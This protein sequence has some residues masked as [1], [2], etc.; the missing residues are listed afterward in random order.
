MVE[1]Q[2]TDSQSGFIRRSDTES[3][4]TSC[5]HSIKTERPIAL[6]EAEDIQPMFALGSQ[7]PNCTTSSCEGPQLRV[8]D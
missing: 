2:N 5:S 8:S 3:I 6:E 7:V 1:P 4:C